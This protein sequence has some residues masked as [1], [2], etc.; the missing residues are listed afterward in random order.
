M[1]P[2]PDGTHLM[3]RTVGLW[4]IFYFHFL[5]TL[6]CTTFALLRFSWLNCVLH[7]ILGKAA[8]KIRKNRGLLPN[9][10]A[11]GLRGY[12][13]NQTP[14]V[15]MYFLKWAC[16]TILGPL[17]H[18]LHLAWSVYVTS[19]A[20]KITLKVELLRFFFPLGVRGGF[21]KRPP[22]SGFFFATFPLDR[23]VAIE[24]IHLYPA[25][26]RCC[27]NL[28]RWISLAPLC[29]M[30]FPSNRPIPVGNW[31][32]CCFYDMPFR[33]Y[34]NQTGNTHRYIHKR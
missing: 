2:C 20:I 22:F 8:K 26:A 24:E 10:G 27:A 19:K 14:S 32:K 9:W 1:I 29:P 31:Q 13:K 11:V 17:K 15:M 18:V 30:S 7:F 34:Q 23:S 5:K 16:K 4:C 33:K 6:I 25:E 3:S 21:G 28:I 12:I